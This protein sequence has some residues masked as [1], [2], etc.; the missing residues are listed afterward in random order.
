MHRVCKR[1]INNLNMGCS[2]VHSRLLMHAFYD[3]KV[4]LTKQ[5]LISKTEYFMLIKNYYDHTFHDRKVRLTKQA[6]QIIII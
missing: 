6:Q 4:R 2:V 5:P 1:I 3:R